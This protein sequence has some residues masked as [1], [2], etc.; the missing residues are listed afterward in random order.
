MASADWTILTDSLGAANVARGVTAG[1]T[2]P[3]GGGSFVY[4]FNSKA[5]VDG[6]VGLHNNQANFAPMSKGGSVRGAMKRSLGGG[7][8]GFAPFLFICL[9]GSSVNDSGY[10]LGLGDDDPAHIVLRKGSI[11][12]GLPDNAAN[13]PTND[14]LM[15]STETFE[16]DTWVHLRLD[17]IVQ[18]SGD[19]LLQVFQN[20][21][22]SYTVSSPTWANI[23]GMEGP[24]YPSITGFVD[25]ALGVNTGSAPYTSGR[26]GFAFRVEDVTRR[27]FFDHCEI[28]R[29]L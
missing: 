7:K 3:N 21:L 29:Q 27:V 6:A 25:D 20:D 28:A 5:I 2:K 15:R 8:T 13:P 23:T 26:G 4:G 1:I 17:A 12:T 22:D 9:G 18:G 10:L 24:Q 14:I 19:V 11:V 16:E